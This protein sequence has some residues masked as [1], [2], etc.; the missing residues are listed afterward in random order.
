MLELRASQVRAAEGESAVSDAYPLLIPV[1][2][3]KWLT[4]YRPEDICMVLIGVVM[5]V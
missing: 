5:M 3:D 4:K 1:Q 2:A